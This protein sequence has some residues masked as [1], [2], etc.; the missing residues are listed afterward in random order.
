MKKD[1]ISLVQK[2]ALEEYS[3]DGGI[4]KYPSLELVRNEKKFFNIHDN[5]PKLLEYGFGSGCNTECL[6]E[7]GYEIYGIDVSKTALANTKKRLEQKKINY[8]K[9]LHLSLINE[10]TK[11]LNFDDNYFDYNP[12]LL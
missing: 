4:K 6:L 9:K 12:H 7:E 3:A 11:V 10:N 8:N 1:E 2:V 5:T